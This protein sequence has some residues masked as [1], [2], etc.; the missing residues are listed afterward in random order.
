MPE[1]PQLTKQALVGSNRGKGRRFRRDW[2]LG[3]VDY[4]RVGIVRD[5]Q[6]SPVGLTGLRKF[7]IELPLTRKFAF[8]L[9]GI[10]FK[11]IER[12]FPVDA[13]RCRPYLSLFQGRFAASADLRCD[14]LTSCRECKLDVGK[15]LEDRFR[16]RRD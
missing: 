7:G 10:R 13:S 5:S 6:G 15:P 12:G 11:K 4:L 2:V 1:P 16:R 3:V 8:I 14:L 9:D